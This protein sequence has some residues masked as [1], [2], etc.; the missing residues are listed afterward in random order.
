MCIYNPGGEN[1]SDAVDMVCKLSREKNM[2]FNKRKFQTILSSD[3]IN[4]RG[5]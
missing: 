2:K 4:F 3:K 1:N 5:H